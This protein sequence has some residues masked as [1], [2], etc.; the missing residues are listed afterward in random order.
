MP[1]HLWWRE[2][3]SDKRVNTRRV[4]EIIEAKVDMVTTACPYCVVMFE[5]ALKA[6]GAEE[7]LQVKDL[8]ELVAEALLTDG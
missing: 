6:E 3:E 4:R 1:D 5:D 8:S 2:E 7:T